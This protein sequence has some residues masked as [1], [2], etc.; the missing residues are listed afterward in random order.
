MPVWHEMLGESDIWNVITFLF[1]YNGQVPRIWDP[2]VS[3]AVTGIKDELLAQR[4]DMQG[5]EL[6]AFRCEVCH[7]EQGMGDGVAADF[8]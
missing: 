2:E 8:M 3:K 6:Y 5:K 7:G 4:R 1:D